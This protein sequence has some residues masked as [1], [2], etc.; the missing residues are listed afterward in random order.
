MEETQ[1]GTPIIESCLVSTSSESNAKLTNCKRKGKLGTSKGSKA[2]KRLKCKLF[3]L[4][5]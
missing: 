5:A 2:K 1:E 4:L 3:M